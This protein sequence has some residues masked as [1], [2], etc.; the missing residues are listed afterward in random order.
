MMNTTQEFEVLFKDG[1]DLA[2][3]ISMNATMAEVKGISDKENN[4]IYLSGSL[5]RYDGS[6]STWSIGGTFLHES[7]NHFHPV[8]DSETN[9]P[10]QN[11]YGLPQSSIEHPGKVETIWTPQETERLKMLRSKT[12]K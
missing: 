11:Y 12:G 6:S 9:I 5:Q 3:A 4:V 10:L 7:I 8:G 2:P 1:K